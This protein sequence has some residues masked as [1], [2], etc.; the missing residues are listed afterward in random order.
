MGGRATLASASSAAA[1]LRR[2]ADADHPAVIAVVDEWW[3]G[4]RMRTSLP[5]LWFR[6]FSGTSWVA[7]TPDGRLMGF[8]VGFV[9]PDTPSEAVLHLVGVDPNVRRRGLGRR[10][11]ERFAADAIERGAT[12]ISAVVPA[13]DRPALDFFRAL[14]FRAIDGPG[15]VRLWGSPAFEDL[16]GPGADRA[17]LVRD[18]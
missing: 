6:H 4:R 12:R 13:D 5:R 11:V 18:R 10:L 9:S 8:L 2:P 15:T 14:G 3:A 16:D 7:E 17:I 1:T